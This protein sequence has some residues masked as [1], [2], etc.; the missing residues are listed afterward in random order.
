M[1]FIPN[2]VVVSLDPNVDL[3]LDVYDDERLCKNSIN[4]LLNFWTSNS[5]ITGLNFISAELINNDTIAKITISPGK[6]YMDGD[7]INLPDNS[8]IEFPLYKYIPFTKIDDYTIQ[9][10]STYEQYINSDYVD[11]ND[12]LELLDQTF[13]DIKP[14]YVNNLNNNQI[15][16]NNPIPENTTHI[17]YRYLPINKNS[18]NNTYKFYL[19]LNYR[20]NLE[21]FNNTNKLKINIYSNLQESDLIPSNDSQDILL[22]VFDYQIN[23]GDSKITS[24]NISQD[25]LESTVCNINDFDFVVKPLNG[26]FIFDGGL[27]V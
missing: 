21:I 26:G 14:I 22:Y 24:I 7:L 20:H 10:S 11:E 3:E 27:V 8:E 5:I 25:Y 6:I 2:D 23:N 4:S 15:V 19:F 1:G 18:S 12:Y 9:F 17:L 16:S 13:A